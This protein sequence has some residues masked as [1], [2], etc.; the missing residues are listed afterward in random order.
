MDVSHLFEPIKLGMAFDSE[1]YAYEYY[2]KYAATIGFSVRKE[3]ANKSKV[4]GYV[5]SRKFICYKEGYRERDKREAMVKKPRKEIRTGCLAH[6][7]VS[8]QSNGKFSIISFE[9]KHNH[10]LVPPSLAHMLP[11]QRNIKLS[12]A[13]EIDLLDDSGI[14]PKSSFDYASRLAGGKASLGYTKWDHINYLRDKRK[15]SLKQGVAHSLVDYFEKRIYGNVV[16]FDITYRTNK[17]YRPLAL[18]VGLNNHREMVVFGAALLY[19]EIAEAF[20]WL[21]TIFFRAIKLLYYYE[22]GDDFLNAWEEMLEKY[23]VK[24]NSW[25]ENT[26]AIRKKWSMTYGKNLFKH[27]QRAIDDKRAN[28]NKSN[29][30]MTKRISVLNVK[31]PLLIHARE[32]YTATIFD[33]FEKEWEKSL[34]ISINGFHDEEEFVNTMLALMEVADSM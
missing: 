20:E 11:S 28:E 8:R 5:T 33:L 19:D 26:F 14:C 13:Y 4:H 32:I 9:K 21:F 12:Q 2:N 22:Y 18:F 34:L 24:D 1:E 10:P 7:V 16:S 27:F 25:L 17:E 29:F 6:M 15:E 3:Y 23:D 31:L 30:D